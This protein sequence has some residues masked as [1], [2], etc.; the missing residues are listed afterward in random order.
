MR[1]RGAVTWLTTRLGGEL[2]RQGM[3]GRR[4]R[5]GGALGGRRRCMGGAGSM[6]EAPTVPWLSS[7]RSPG[8]ETDGGGQP[9]PPVPGPKLPWEEQARL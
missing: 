8:R 1:S 5:V 4:R 9:L 6:R 3:P 2:E 7:R